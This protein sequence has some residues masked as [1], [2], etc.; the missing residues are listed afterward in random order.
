MRNIRYVSAKLKIYLVMI[1]T[2]I[3]FWG[4]INFNFIVWNNKLN[5]FYHVTFSILVNFILLHLKIFNASFSATS[6]STRFSV[7]PSKTYVVITKLKAKLIYVATQ[8]IH[9]KIGRVYFVY[10]ETFGLKYI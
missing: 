6:S 3:L 5:L 7:S 2:L 9:C 4:V 8:N 1:K 10:S